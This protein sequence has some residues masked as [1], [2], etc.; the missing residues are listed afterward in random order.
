M[1]AKHSDYQRQHVYNWQAE[2]PEGQRVK[3]EHAQQL[4][5]Y[6]WAQE[7][8]LYPPKVGPIAKNTVRWAGAANRSI[9]KLQPVVSTRT[10]L[11]EMAHSMT[12]SAITDMSHQHN[13][14]FVGVYMRLLE[15]YMN[16]GMPLL[17]FSASKHKVNYDQFAR[18]SILDK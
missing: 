3:L 13:E 10:V 5:D 12:S 8:L 17:M 2:L 14:V 4:V 7:G 11:H 9:I 16:I 15:K 18:P 6:V 1:T